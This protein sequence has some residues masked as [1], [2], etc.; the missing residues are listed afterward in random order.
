M[1]GRSP[2]RG[3]REVKEIERLM[4]GSRASTALTMLDLPAPDGAE[5]MKRLPLM[6]SSSPYSM[7]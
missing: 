6:F 4:L 3:F 7:F 1:T 5:T 2:G